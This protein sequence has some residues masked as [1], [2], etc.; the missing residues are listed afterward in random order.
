VE[1]KIEAK[2]E[3]RL[4]DVPAAAVYLGISPWYVRQLQWGKK[5]PVVRIGSK[6]LFDRKDLDAYVER[7]KLGAA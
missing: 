3:A 6:V 7:A 1:T 2:V 4:L 5:V